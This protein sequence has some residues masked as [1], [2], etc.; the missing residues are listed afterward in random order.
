MIGGFV[1]A[2]RQWIDGGIWVVHYRRDGGA[3]PIG[4]VKRLGLLSHTM[5][6]S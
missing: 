5:A 1:V 3:T 4:M 6:E 2:D